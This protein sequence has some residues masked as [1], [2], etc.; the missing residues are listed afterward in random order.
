MTELEMAVVDWLAKAF[1]L[2][3]LFLNSSPG[4][5]AG[6]IQVEFD[7]ILSLILFVLN[8]VHSERLHARGA[9]VRT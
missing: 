1:Q 2:P 6:M 8:L 9:A 3:Q 4:Y 5:G 7:T